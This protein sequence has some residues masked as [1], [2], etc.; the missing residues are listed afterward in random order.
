MTDPETLDFGLTDLDANTTDLS[1]HEPS[2]ASNQEAHR[3][4]GINDI[5]DKRKQVIYDIKK[6][7][8]DAS[9]YPVIFKKFAEIIDKT[10]E[11]KFLY[12][13]PKSNHEAA[14]RT[15]LMKFVATGKIGDALVSSSMGEIKKMAK[16][17]AIE[18]LRYI[19]LS[20]DHPTR[21]LQALQK[22]GTLSDIINFNLHKKHYDIFDP[23]WYQ[24]YVHPEV[25]KL[26]MNYRKTDQRE[27][28]GHFQESL[29]NIREK[30]KQ[31]YC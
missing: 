12:L 6:G 19:P 1:V 24:T 30:L 3:Y 10:P 20:T 22:N 31:I 27:L 25:M 8:L 11:G 17:I 14:L 2:A 9:E 21:K 18:V 26:I 15:K 28:R 16:D 13:N 29:S 23:S 7:E 4:D 5:Q